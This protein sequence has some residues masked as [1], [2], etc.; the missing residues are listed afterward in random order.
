MTGRMV[1]AGLAWLAGIACGGG[2]DSGLP[3]GN[4]GGDITVG[5]NF[6][7]PATFSVAPNG[8]VTWTWNSSGVEHNVTFDDGTKSGTQGSGQFQ[9][10]FT[11]AGNYNYHCTIHGAAAMSGTITVSASGST[12]GGSGGG[13]GGGGGGGYGGG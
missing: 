8:T 1:L 13:G 10:T 12:S 11:T 9:R 7:N 6:F 3:S 4:N 2:A 5:N